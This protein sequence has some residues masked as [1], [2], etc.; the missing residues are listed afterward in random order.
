MNLA[1]VFSNGQIT[2]PA[3]IRR[4][5]NLKEGDKILF[6]EREDG[7]IVIDNASVSTKIRTKAGSESDLQTK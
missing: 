7:E 1:K 5:L 2:V 4:M 3:E 6:L